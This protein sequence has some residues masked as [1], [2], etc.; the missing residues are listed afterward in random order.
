MTSISFSK[1]HKHADAVKRWANVQKYIIP[2]AE[3]LNAEILV[4]DKHGVCV[5][6]TSHYEE[7]FGTKVEEDNALS[8]SLR[9]GESSYVLNPGCEDVCK[10]CSKRQGCADIANFTGPVLVDGKI[11]AVVQFVAHTHHQ[12]AELL[13]KAEQAFELF[14]HL[15]Q[16]AWQ[17]EMDASIPIRDANTF[18]FQNLI[19]KSAPIEA[20][21]EKILKIAPSDSTILIQGESGT[22][23]E[24][25]ARAIH[26]NSTRK[27]KPFI[28]INCGAIPESLM[29]SE[30]FGYAGGAFSGADKHGRGGLLEEAHEGTL[31][32]DEISE[33]P[34]ALQVK[35]LRCLQEGTVRR[36]GANAQQQIDIRVIAASNKNLR[37]MV[38][39]GLFR[40][41]LYF[42]LDVVPLHIPPLRERKED[43]SLLTAY[44][45]RQ[46]SRTLQKPFRISTNLQNLFD[47]YSWPGNV[48][49]LKNFVEYGVSLCEN[50]VLT[51]EIML[52]RFTQEANQ[53]LQNSH[54]THY[55]YKQNT[56]K[57][58]Q[59][60]LS[61]KEMAEKENISCILQEYAG[62]KGGKQEVAKKLGMSLA[63]LYRKLQKYDL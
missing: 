8:Y 43:I 38:Q 20:L 26:Y 56:E 13:S 52:P 41:D 63:T 39:Q 4:L 31:F 40:E 24:V 25:V 45:L 21:K 53:S 33:M 2:L 51:S 32:L 46:F 44:F 57:S 5:S 1:A 11:I 10:S 28:P 16:F 48:R 9:T 19:G 12:R 15:V 49:E 35:L 30:L 60:H 58:D 7:R 37:H 47:N 3:L 29:E 23:K 61:N 50:G 34:L 22:G 36:V 17:H 18:C 62:L 55:N 54:S 14:K 42:R 6:G 27:A 59:P